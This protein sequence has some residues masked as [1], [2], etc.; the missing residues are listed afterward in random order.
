VRECLRL[1][2]LIP[3][4]P[5]V[6]AYPLEKANQALAELKQGDIRGAKVLQVNQ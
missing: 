5:R 6:T 2:A 1:A 4:H 3:L